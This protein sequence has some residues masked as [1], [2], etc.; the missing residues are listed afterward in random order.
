MVFVALLWVSVATMSALGSSAYMGMSLSAK[1]PPVAPEHVLRVL[2]EM[3]ED[4]DEFITEQDVSRFVSKHNLPF[5]AADIASMF[6]EANSS[7]DGLMDVEQLGK[8]VSFKFAHRRHNEDWARLFELAPHPPPYATGGDLNRLTALSPAPLEQEPIRANFE[9]EPSILTF[10][11]LT[12]TATGAR[13]GT[14]TGTGASIT[15][16]STAQHSTATSAP[17]NP[18][19]RPLY[20]GARMGSEAERMHEAVINRHLQPDAHLRPP[21]QAAAPKPGVQLASFHSGAPPPRCGFSAKEAFALSGE[22][23]KRVSVAVGWKTKLPEDYRQAVEDAK[24]RLMY[25]GVHD[26]DFY[27]TP[28]AAPPSP[29][30][31]PCPCPPWPLAHPC[32]DLRQGQLRRLDTSTRRWVG[33]ESDGRES[34]TIPAADADRKLSRLPCQLEDAYRVHVPRRRKWSAFC[35]RL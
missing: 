24:P 22:T 10:E 15:S 23:E 32:H 28:C 6:A 3:D 20:P 16:F 5:S 17:F 30:P 25:Y 34:D 29:H 9:Q 14:G 13:W 18:A 33:D 26:K 8:A 19:P 12:N 11:P 31:H 2:H 35:Q 7:Q 1:P 21:A 4:L 27:Y